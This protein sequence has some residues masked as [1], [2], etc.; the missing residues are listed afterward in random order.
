MDQVLSSPRTPFGLESR[1]TGAVLSRDLREL[2]GSYI[3]GVVLGSSE[4]A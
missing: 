3:W 4:L 2:G 1:E